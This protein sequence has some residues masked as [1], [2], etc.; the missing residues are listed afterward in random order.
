MSAAAAAA[1]MAVALDA[2]GHVHSTWSD[3]TATPAQ[4]VAAAHAA[5]LRQLVMVDHVRRSTEWL[6]GFVRA[7]EVLRRDA[8]LL[9][10]CGVEAK[11]LDDRGTLDL[12]RD[13]SGVDVILVADHRMP[14]P[15]G[16]A[17]PEAVRAALAGGTL[18]P[19]WL[20][21]RLVAA[22]LA[23][24]EAPRP[25]VV[26]HLFSILP[27]VGLREADVP[28]EAIARLADRCRETGAVVELNEKWATPG[29]RTLTILH[30]R[31]AGLVAGSDAHAPDAVGRWDH[32]AALTAGLVA[33][34]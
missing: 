3:G 28:D 27:K 21:E 5:G 25:V 30:Q 24:L 6:P 10:R 13:L 4:N 8:G 2:D 33:G 9:L 20:I 29:P 12:P 16:P 11:I 17:A 14:L 32:V 18:D 15:S 31:G 7:V 23:A 19:R 22:T 1:T 34:S 26:A